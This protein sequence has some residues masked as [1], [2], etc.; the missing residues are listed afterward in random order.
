MD[1]I[2]SF[3]QSERLFEEIIPNSTSPLDL[4]P[5]EIEIYLSQ[6][7]PQLCGKLIKDLGFHFPLVKV[8]DN[9]AIN[10]ENGR[11][12]HIWP[13]LGHLRRV[14]RVKLDQTLSVQNNKN[15]ESNEG[16]CRKSHAPPTKR[17][18]MNNQGTNKVSLEV[19]IGSVKHID[20]LFEDLAE[21]D[22]KRTESQTSLEVNLKELIQK[23]N[24]KLVKRI[25]PGRPAKSREE[26]SDWA[27][28]N[29]GNGWWPSL[30][31]EKQ[32]TTY[33]EKELELD[34]EEELG[35][36][37]DCMMD[38][39]KD[40]E[41]HIKRNEL[42]KNSQ[43]GAIIVDPKTNNVISRSQD[44]WNEKLNESGGSKE[45]Y[46]LL[47][48]VLNTPVL[49]AIQGVSRKEREGATGHGMD[50]DKFKGGQYLCT[51]YDA[52]LTRE[53]SIFEAMALVHS[54]VRRVIFGNPNVHDGGLG[55]SEISVHSLPGTNHRF[56]A[57]RVR[58]MEEFY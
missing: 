23:Y 5:D 53:P 55:G 3:S 32:S 14:R 9:S 12:E 2:S 10:D 49:M 54:R 17:R 6:V 36:M 26:L 39:I 24:L 29:E 51:G 22:N 57:F 45:K 43:I 34:L 1:E 27:I 33:K 56:R 30:F 58:N 37:K 16:K 13:L 28:M 31:F 18:K 48:N 11:K 38:A 20:T 19:M 42:A 25:V 47:E 41:I 35:T 50:S 8:D 4:L 15:D 21:T 40:G 44:E 46:L 7:E 52:Y